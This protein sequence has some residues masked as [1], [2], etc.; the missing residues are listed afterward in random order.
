[1]LQFLFL[2]RADATLTKGRE[3][4]SCEATALAHAATHENLVVALK[5]LQVVTA[6]VGADDGPLLRYEPL[7]TVVLSLCTRTMRL[8]FADPTQEQLMVEA[9]HALHGCAQRPT[10]IPEQ[11]QIRSS[12]SLLVYISRHCCLLGGGRP[13]GAPCG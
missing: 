13:Q 7:R 6:L 5:A 4:V 12:S 8:P 11:R 1:M 10:P 9:V 2:F 3:R